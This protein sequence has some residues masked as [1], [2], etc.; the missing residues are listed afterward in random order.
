MKKKKL[1]TSLFLGLGLLTAITSC[2]ESFDENFPDVEI[3]NNAPS[4]T[5]EID[6]V[7]L[8]LGFSESTLDLAAYVVDAE[9]DPLTV[10]ATSSDESI[11]KVTA[12]GAILTFEEGGSM[13]V[14]TISAT[15]TD[16]NEGNE[17]SF[18]FPVKVSDVA[19]PTFAYGFDFTLPN[20][21]TNDDIEWPDGATVEF[22]SGSGGVTRTIQ[23]G[24]SFWDLPAEGDLLLSLT[25]D[26]PADISDNPTFQ[27]DYADSKNSILY[28]EFY[29]ASGGFVSVE[30]ELITDDPEFNT[31]TVDLSAFSEDLDLTQFSGMALEKYIDWESD[32]V[33]NGTSW[34]IDNFI[35]GPNN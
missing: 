27:L 3:L 28:L 19:G 13:G 34:I 35:I 16:G 32:E 18:D 29:D 8:T 22:S 2:R 5:G 31:L 9:D 10:A 1:L 26:A 15:L 25:L 12:N 33:E 7:S 4:L 30:P 6:T 17:I 20:G 21:T 14:A 11:V 23:N 24:A